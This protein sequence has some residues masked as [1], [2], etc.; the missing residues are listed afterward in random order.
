[1]AYLAAN[2]VRRR[3]AV[4]EHPDGTMRA[5]K[6]LGWL[7]RNWQDV[8]RLEWHTIPRRDGYPF[9][10]EGVFTAVMRDGRVYRTDYADFGVWTRFIDRPVFRNLP[11][12]V[13]GI[14]GTV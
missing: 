6:N 11:V 1:M 14:E 7:L 4:V 3:G 13:D 8:A 2:D 5:V 9:Y 12:T 10:P